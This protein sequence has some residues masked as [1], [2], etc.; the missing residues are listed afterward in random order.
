MRWPWQKNPN[1][2]SDSPA[3]RPVYK[4]PISEFDA[5]RLAQTG[6]WVTIKVQLMPNGRWTNWKHDIPPELK[7]EA[8]QA[9]IALVRVLQAEQ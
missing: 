9:L 7:K 5:H 4:E 6:R 3:V 1:K 8:T 2:D